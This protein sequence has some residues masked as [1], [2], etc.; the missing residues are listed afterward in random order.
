MQAQLLAVGAHRLSRAELCAVDVQ[1]LAQLDAQVRDQPS[2]V[3]G[4]DFC[5]GYF[6]DHGVLQTHDEAE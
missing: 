6:G 5:L 1:Q 2:H 4:T 3:G